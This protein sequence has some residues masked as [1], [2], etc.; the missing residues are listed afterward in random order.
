VQTVRDQMNDVHEQPLLGHVW[1]KA[2]ILER[3]QRFA[4]TYGDAPSVIDWNPTAARR[5]GRADLAERF[6]ADG[7]WP[8][9]NTVRRVF[10]SWRRALEEAGYTAGSSGGA[11]AREAWLEDGFVSIT[12]IAAMAGVNR[13]D[14]RRPL[15]RSGLHP[16]ETRGRTALYRRED[17]E[18]F[19]R[20]L[21]AALD[22][23]AA[24]RSSRRPDPPGH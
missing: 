24:A 22:D 1:G 3:I 8:H 9:A 12:D 10:G 19:A 11:R 2:A 5:R 4:A 17:A 13:F 21:R 16:A 20:R 7:C 14:V 18:A 6:H 23:R 15:A